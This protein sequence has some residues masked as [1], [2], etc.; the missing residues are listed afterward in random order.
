LINEFEESC[1]TIKKHFP[2]F[3]KQLYL[4]GENIGVSPWYSDDEGNLQRERAL[5]AAISE[6]ESLL[7][8]P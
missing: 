3:K 8:K 2:E 1:Y 6:A 4:T 7:L 5:L